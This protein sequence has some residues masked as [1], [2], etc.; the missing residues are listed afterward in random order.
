MKIL[1]FS[2]FA[3]LALGVG[4]GFAATHQA[5]PKTLPVVMHDPGCHWFQINGKIATAATV[6]GPIQIKDMDE[7]TLKIASR[8]GSRFVH[9]GK[10]ITLSRGYYVVMMVGQAV[11]DNYLQ[12]TVR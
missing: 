11:D 6:A 7:N 12:L 2:L 5:A 8:S 3:A 9:V 1:I 10:S 4:Q